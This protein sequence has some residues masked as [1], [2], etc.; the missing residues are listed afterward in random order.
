M[1]E[2]KKRFWLCIL[3]YA[4]TFNHIH[5]LVLDTDENAIP[6]AIQLVAGRT[7]KMTIA[8]CVSVDT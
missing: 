2:A 1:F 4:V 8:H 6:N 7:K 3:N 5:M